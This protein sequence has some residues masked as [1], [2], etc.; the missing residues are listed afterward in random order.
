MWIKEG[1]GKPSPEHFDDHY[2]VAEGAH[3]MLKPEV[4]ER[5]DEVLAI[6]TPVDGRRVLDLGGGALMGRAC[7]SASKYVCVD[8]SKEACRIGR[9]VAPW[10]DMRQADVEDF[11][12][13]NVLASEDE[14]PT[15]FAE[16]FDV[17]VSVGILDY[18]PGY[19]LDLLFSKCPSPV[20]ALTNA[21]K[22]A[23]LKYEARITIPSRE[24]V[25]AAAEKWGWKLV[26]EIKK[27]DHVWARF[28]RTK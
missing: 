7:G 20:L 24:D 2:R 16:T 26:R 11:L 17:T 1:R 21:V 10:A 27:L 13:R 12:R 19:G 9:H 25:L 6:T 18:L 8:Y 14:R 15:V 23:Y 5:L 4:Q 22:E 28:E 3:R